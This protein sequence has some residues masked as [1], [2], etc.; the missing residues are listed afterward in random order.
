[1]LSIIV[2]SHHAIKIS[3]AKYDPS[4]RWYLYH[5]VNVMLSQP[6]NADVKLELHYD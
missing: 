2:A 1:M 5:E 4:T 3:G 6:H